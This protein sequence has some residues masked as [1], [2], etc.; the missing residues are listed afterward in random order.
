M[1]QKDICTLIPEPYRSKLVE[2]ANS[3]P[4]HLINYKLDMIRMEAAHYH[5]QLFVSAEEAAARLKVE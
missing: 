2:A 1:I 5:P 3:R 4:K